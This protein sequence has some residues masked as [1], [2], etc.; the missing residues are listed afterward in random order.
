[1]AAMRFGDYEVIKEIG[2]GGMGKVYLARNIHIPEMIVVLKRLKDSS[3]KVRFKKEAVNLSKL[4]HN[5]IC[6]LKHFFPHNDELIIVMQYI[7]GMILSKWADSIDSGKIEKIELAF[8]QILDGLGYAHQME[9]FHRDIKPANVLVD[10]NDVIKI[11]DFGIARHTK[12]TRLTQPGMAIGTFE[13]MAPELLSGRGDINWA[14]CDIYSVGSSLYRLCCGRVPFDYSDKRI[15]KFKLYTQPPE[16]PSNLN[17]EIPLD[18]EEVILKAMAT[19]PQDRYAS[20][21]EMRR[22][23]MDLGGQDVKS[24]LTSYEIIKEI[25]EGG[26]GKVYLARNKYLPNM[27]VVLKILKDFAQKERFLAEANALSMLEHTNI[28]QLKHFFHH[29]NELVIVM[30]YIDGRNLTDLVINRDDI[31]LNYIKKIFLQVLDGL[32]YAHSKSVHH[33]DIKP[34]NIMIDRDDNVKIIDFGIARHRTDVRWTQTGAAVGTPQYMAPEQFISDRLDDYSFCDIYSAGIT[35]YELCCGR[36]PF[37]DTNPYVLK[38]KHCKATP[39][40]PGKLNHEISSELEDVILKAI[41]KKPSKRFKSVIDMR[42]ALETAE[43]CQSDLQTIPVMVRRGFKKKLRLTLSLIGV[44]AIVAIIYLRFFR[45]DG[46]DTN[47]NG[48]ISS[49][50]TTGQSTINSAP[51]ITGEL[52]QQKYTDEDFDPVGLDAFVEDDES[53]DSLIIWSGWA[54]NFSVR[55]DEERILRVIPNPGWTGEERVLLIAADPDGAVDSV[56]ARFEVRLRPAPVQ[57]TTY[58]LQLNVRQNESAIYDSINRYIGPEVSTNVRPGDYQYFVYNPDYPIQKIDLSV[59]DKAIDTTID[60]E[61]AAN[62]DHKGFL[63]VTVSTEDYTFYDCEIIL[64]GFRTGKMSENT[65]LPEL[66]VGD[67]HIDVVLP[68]TLL[69]DSIIVNDSIRLDQPSIVE[70]NAPSDA[71]PQGITYVDFY[72]SKK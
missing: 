68:N 67:Y 43:P 14:L 51:V 32:V 60:L 30:Q 11:I 13:Y 62:W 36:L 53:P 55:I 8:I 12:D 27:Q 23:L 24:D 1:M 42:N 5:N 46:S 64:N 34:S 38:D 29:T 61:L 69:L 25:G 20:C 19:D 26:M 3:Q 48:E 57:P 21:E 35:L 63:A 16:K 9:I 65:D 22:A 10:K 17:P 72:V 54:N 47:G 7:E 44:L 4:E 49:V 66:Y 58:T 59:S 37:E 31:D 15:V 40:K 71:N 2:E 70:I 18:L 39:E 41:E 56:Y 52:T 6:Q 28:C 50:A 33:R 45:G